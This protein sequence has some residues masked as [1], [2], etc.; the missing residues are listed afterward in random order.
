MTQQADQS[1]HFIGLG[2]QKSGT[3]WVYACLYEHPE[4]CAPVK[5]IHFFSRPRYREGKE[6]YEAH[7]TKC[8]EGKLRGEF[9]TSYLYSKEA[10]ERIKACY[11]DAKLIAILRN[12]INRAYSQYRNS[13]KAGE[14]PESVS[15]EEFSERET[16]VR[17]QGRYTEQLERYLTYFH[18]EQL[19]VLIYE[20][21]RKDPVAFMRLIY[22]FLG[23]DPDFVSS[24]VHDEINVARTPKH[25]GI[26]RVMHHTAEFLRRH[27]FDRLVH[28]IRKLGLPD[29]IRS[30]NTKEG[31]KRGEKPPYDR[32]ALAAYFRD[33]VE[34]LS[35]L[36][37]RDMNKEW[38]I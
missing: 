31:A 24:M 34:K 8:G 29:L 21:I 26:E 36:L 27:G 13:I 32:A 19:L 22:E 17:E 6:W 7:F 4:V 28:H 14:I 15:F 20:D 30:V 2:A 16:S 23:I 38:N 1:I 18:R 33:D 12:P 10:P 5:E 25:I 9:S 35:A 3:S 37:E 11:S